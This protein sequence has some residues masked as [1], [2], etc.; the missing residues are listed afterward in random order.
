MRPQALIKFPTHLVGDAS[1]VKECD[2][3]APDIG[4]YK[5]L[6]AGRYFDVLTFKAG[7]WVLHERKEVTDR[8]YDGMLPDPRATRALDD[9]RRGL[10]ERLSDS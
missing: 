2:G 6:K 9:Y 4:P 3:Y 1:A 10:N 7:K 5:A 8:Y